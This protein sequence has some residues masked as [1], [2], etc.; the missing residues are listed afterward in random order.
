MKRVL[1]MLLFVLPLAWAQDAVVSGPISGGGTAN[2]IAKW[3]S[4]TNLTTSALCQ[5]ATG[6][7]V[8]IATCAPTQRLQVNSGN[9]L[10]RGVNNFTADGQVAK[11]YVGDTNHS[12]SATFGTGL[13]FSTY[14]APKAMLIYDRTGWVVVNTNLYAQFLFAG[15]SSRPGGLNVS[16]DAAINGTAFVQAIHFPDNTVQTTAYTGTAAV[17]NQAE[18]NRQLLRDRDNLVRVVRQLQTR[19]AQLERSSRK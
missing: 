15:D 3:S 17:A 1:A 18:I 6:G 19:V 8:G 16:G 13:T 9:V 14:Q 11:Y 10:V 7:L 5:S 2:Y 12:L 4:S